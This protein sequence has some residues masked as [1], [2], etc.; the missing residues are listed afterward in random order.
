VTLVALRREEGYRYGMTP[1]SK[2]FIRR[3]WSDLGEDEA[4]LKA[5]FEDW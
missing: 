1:R 4:K 2:M 3:S 5:N